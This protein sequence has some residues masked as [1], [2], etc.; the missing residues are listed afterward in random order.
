[1]YD[2]RDDIAA[3][4]FLV[5]SADADMRRR[6]TENLSEIGYPVCEA[7]GVEM[8]GEGGGDGDFRLILADMKSLGGSFWEFMAACRRNHPEV[9]IIVFADRAEVSSACAAARMGALDFIITPFTSD[10]FQVRIHKALNWIA[11]RDEAAGLRRRIALDYAFDNFVGVSETV[12]SIRHRAM[13]AAEID[14]PLLITGEPGS[15][16]EHLAKIIH[17]HSRR[18]NHPIRVCEDADMD[19]SS[20][21]A[22]GTVIIKTVESLSER[23]R[24]Y[25]SVQLHEPSEYR[26]ILL[27]APGTETAVGEQIPTIEIPPLRARPDDIPVLVEY[28]LRRISDDSGRL[29]LSVAP[30]T[31]RRLVRYEWP[32]NVGELENMLKTAIALTSGDVIEPDH[33]IFL[34]PDHEAAASASSSPRSLEEL[35]RAQIRRSLEGNGWNFSQTAQELGIGRTTLWRKIKKYDLK[36]AAMA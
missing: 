36:Q 9:E 26:L 33:L 30:E 21:D 10:E 27:G 3:S 8:V 22:A 18:R 7:G 28:F 29:G 5:I 34:S 11:M 23:G 24:A 16:R 1:M 4:S 25:L 31:M 12:E 14:S 19:W 2:T 6:L 13:R 20:A 35:E 17:I 32:G 15:G